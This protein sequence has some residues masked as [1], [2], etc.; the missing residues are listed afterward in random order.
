MKFLIVLLLC[1]SQYAFSEKLYK[2]CVA[3]HG[4]DA[5]GKKAP[6]APRLAGQKAWYIEDQ[7]KLF[8]SKK[9][10]GGRSKTM[11]GVAA[12]LSKEDMKKLAKYLEE[13]AK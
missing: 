9:R 6:R 1:F 2:K 12:K 7:L 13:L 11:Y 4:K 10:K 3:C 8:K 5:M